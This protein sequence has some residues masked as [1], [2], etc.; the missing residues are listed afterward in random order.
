MIRFLILS[1]ILSVATAF[2]QRPALSV[3]GSVVDSL[4]K[5]PLEYSTVI[6]F[7]AQDST[8]VA[9]IATNSQGLFKLDSL[10][11]GQYFA[12]VNFLGYELKTLRDI[13]LNRER[14]QAD[15]GRILLNPIALESDEVTVTTERLA[16]EQ[17]VEKK[18]I[19]VA[20]QN[21]APTGTAADI[22]SNAPSVT[23]DIEGNVKLRGSSNFTVMI[24]GRPSILDA[25]DA[26]QQIPAGTIDKIE[27]IT[28]PSSR[29]SAEG[30]AGIINIIPLRRGA[31]GVSGQITA[32]T[33]IDERRNV[34]ATFT[35]PVGI[36][37]LTVGANAGIGREPGESS[38]ETRTTF[39]N[40]TSTVT[41][42][43]NTMGR[44]DNFG[45][46]AELDLPL[47]QR[48]AMVFG[49]RVGDY[50]FGR[51]NELSTWEYSETEPLP[52]HYL[53][54]DRTKHG[55]FHRH[56]FINWKHKFAREEQQLSVD[57][58]F[59]GR[60]GDDETTTELYADDGRILSGVRTTEEGPGRRFEAKSD[61]VHPFANGAKLE[62][63]LSSQFGRFKSDN[64]NETL[65][66][67]AGD[68]VYDALYSNGTDFHRAMQAGYGMYSSKLKS[69]EVQIG[70]RAEY[71]DRSVE[72]TKTGENISLTR[73]DVFPSA[74]TAWQLGGTKQLSASYTRRVEHSRPWF[75]E[76]FLT[77]ENAYNVR[78]GN[79][80]LR[81]EFIDSYEAGYQTSLL[82]QNVAT[83][84]Y[85]RVRHN[86]VEML[87]SVYAENVTL[88]AP[89]NVGRQFSLGTELR[90][91][92]TVRKGWSLTLSGNLYDQRV[93]AELAGKS[94]D[95]HT[96]TYDAKL[97]S[98]T[99]L[100]PNTRIQIDASYNGPTVTS[101]GDTEPSFITN[102][103]LRQD[104]LKK[105]LNVALQVRDLFASARRESLTSTPT[106][107]SVD[108][109]TN[110]APVFTLS[111]TYSFNNFKK[112]KESSRE[113]SSDDF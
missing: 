95:D 113:D 36:A 68:Y 101:Q 98:I 27:I 102:L 52:V 84:A 81:P 57:L 55:G 59:G 38:S 9:G 19:N 83:E 87:R 51:D 88:T 32:R 1:I 50:A 31:N 69:L 17:H 28:N 25:N 103:G 105:T 6:L 26:L 72:Q 91:D 56:G 90:T 107:Y 99:A 92:I 22:L 110:D 41:T 86:Y 14:Q 64:K 43:G 58:S 100:A 23:V 8:Q 96:L 109:F 49:G 108:R 47:G 34:D 71:F 106:L 63:G 78:K 70:L 62:T 7:N 80:K 85:Y 67:L 53:S 4:T 21:I 89:E 35:R 15:L 97:N 40:N 54:R 104:F 37:A 42:D 94:F 60:D 2:A 61:Y 24:D 20:K 13:R 45:F 46:R 65:D 12:R 44:R 48:N 10:R 79:P 16:V 18:V 30:T 39:E 93:N 82:K 5:Q 111:A 66:T 76:P 77:W 29:F 75:L 74:H 112:K 11:P 73:F 3:H 33:S